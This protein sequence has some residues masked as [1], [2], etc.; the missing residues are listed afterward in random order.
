MIRK[1]VFLF[2][3]LTATSNIK[4][5][6]H[7]LGNFSINQYSRIE[8]GASEVR[9]RQIL[10]MAEIPT[11]Q[12]SA[13]IDMDRDGKLSQPERDAYA[14]QF[15][16]AFAANLRLSI[17][18][19]TI[20]LNIESTGVAVGNGAGDLPTLR[21]FWDL[22]AKVPKLKDINNLSFRNLN[23]SDRLGWN[24][25]V[26]ERQAGISVFDSD[27]F[28]SAITDELKAYPQDSLSSPL[29]ERTANFSFST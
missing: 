13:R 24:E 7:P 2:L 22:T 1:I 18:G 10:D 12:E 15:T 17:N 16:P 8:V 14:I 20:P 27:A 21:F 6:A 11:F 29:A 5:S 4:V 28:G 23:Y 26:V 25:I 19:E 3:V 9:I